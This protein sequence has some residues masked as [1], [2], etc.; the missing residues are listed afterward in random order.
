MGRNGRLLIKAAALLAFSAAPLQAAIV[1]NFEA[2]TGKSTPFTDTVGG[3]SA[4]FSNSGGVGGFTV[5]P[6]FLSSLS[7]NILFDPGPASLN[8][9]PLTIAFSAPQTNI[10]LLFATNSVSPVPL[11]LSAF[12]GATL[13]GTATASGVV[14]PAFS[15]PEGMLA[16]GG[17][18]FDSVV[19]TSFAPDFA[20]DNVTVGAV[21]EPASL[22]LAVLGLLA[23]AARRRLAN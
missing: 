15:F 20:I 1:F 18:A 4:T 22:S 5:G 11:L 7:G 21:P 9:L 3:L 8:N 19:L 10:S 23:L 14:P 17:P 12:M 2:D 16:F 13:V 6:N